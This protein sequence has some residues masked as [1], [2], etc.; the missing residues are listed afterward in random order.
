MQL[1]LTVKFQNTSFTLKKKI[2]KY[3]DL[4]TMYQNIYVYLRF[5]RNPLGYKVISTPVNKS[6]TGEL[7]KSDPVR[8]NMFATILHFLNFYRLDLALDSDF[9]PSLDLITVFFLNFIN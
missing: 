1:R 7:M 9:N 5:S 4:D 6:L 2:Y 3:L 8:L